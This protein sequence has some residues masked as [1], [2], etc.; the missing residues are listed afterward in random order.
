VNTNS[1]D[2][3]AYSFL[4]DSKRKVAADLVC[5]AAFNPIIEPTH[6]VEEFLTRRATQL[7]EVKDQIHY[8]ATKLAHLKEESNQ[9]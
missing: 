4:L 7:L 3:Q 1:L 2:I 8:V 9:L 5:D 6:R